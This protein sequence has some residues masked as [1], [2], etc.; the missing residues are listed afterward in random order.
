MT[1]Y[2]RAFNLTVKLAERVLFVLFYEQQ[3][4]VFMLHLFGQTRAR[5]PAAS[6]AQTRRNHLRP[7]SSSA[8]HEFGF[9]V[10]LRHANPLHSFAP[11]DF[12]SRTHGSGSRLIVDPARTLRCSHSVL[13]AHLPSST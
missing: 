13:F 1:A 4:P 6:P 7:T 3:T 9:V 8:E 2:P 11:L 5:V 12:F 10:P